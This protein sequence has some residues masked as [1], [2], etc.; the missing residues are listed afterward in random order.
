MLGSFS[1][2]IG[3]TGSE[4]AACPKAASKPA[5]KLLSVVGGGG[6]GAGSGL[7]QAR[8]QS[9]ELPTPATPGVVVPRGPSDQ[10]RSDR[11]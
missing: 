3:S 11:R 8:I 9:M 5:P 7:A 10:P 4:K 6:G 2:A 1:L